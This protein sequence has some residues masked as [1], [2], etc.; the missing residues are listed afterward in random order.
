MVLNAYNALPFALQKSKTHA[1][2]G[3]V[4]LELLEKRHVVLYILPVR[5][6]CGIAIV[7]L[8]RAITLQLNAV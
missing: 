6:I 8:G 3:S 7:R 1:F 2:I 4:A 5:E